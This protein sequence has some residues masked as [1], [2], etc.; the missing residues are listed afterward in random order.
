MYNRQLS[1]RNGRYIGHT[2]RQNYGHRLPCKSSK[3]QTLLP[4]GLLDTVGNSLKS[5]VD[6]SVCF[7]WFDVQEVGCLGGYLV[8]SSPDKGQSIEP[9]LPNPV[10]S[11]LERTRVSEH[12]HNTV[13]LLTNQSKMC[14]VLL[15][16]PAFRCVES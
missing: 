11:L 1:F 5:T 2:N 13:K 4:L 8:M 6:N 10:P 14:Y 9:F 7:C 15:H 16:R 12:N 3:T